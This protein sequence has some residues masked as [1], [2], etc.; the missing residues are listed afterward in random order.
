MAIPLFNRILWHTNRSPAKHLVKTFRKF[1]T[2]SDIARRRELARNLN[3]DEDTRQVAATVRDNGFAMLH[4]FL[5]NSSLTAVGDMVD[6]LAG[7]TDQA[8]SAF[9]PYKQ[10]V[11]THLVDRAMVDGQLQADNDFVRFATQGKVTGLMSEIFGMV[12]RL[13]YVTVTHSRPMTGAPSFSQL[14]HR[15]HDDT[16]VVKL[17]VYLTDV[18]TT[19][20]GP[21]T[22]IPGPSSDLVGF[23][24]KSHQRD[25]ELPSTIN[26]ETAPRQITGQRFTAFIVET[27]R[28]LHMGS[29]VQPGHERLMLT[30]T[31]FAP[32]RI[33]PEPKRSFFKLTGSES[34]VEKALL[35][36]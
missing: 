16:K 21:F 14:W 3:I 13:D 29:R 19:A 10:S 36:S 27:S 30:A 31:Y 18:E 8:A 7:Q 34:E 5:P 1:G 24:I 20:D 35:G 22:F 26:I 25:E 9:A 28:C 11:W 33:F 32:P 4:G 17:F 6:S 2:Q 15:D 12:P 23:S